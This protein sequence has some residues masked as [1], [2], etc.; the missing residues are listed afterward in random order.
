MK[1][2]LSL[3]YWRNMAENLS[4]PT[5]V[6]IGGRFVDAMSGKTFTV[7]NPAS[8]ET[9][10]Q[11]PLC[12]ETDVANSVIAARKA[13]NTGPWANMPPAE[14]KK[15]LLAFAELILRHKEELALLETLDV[16]KPINDT[17]KEDVP[18]AANAITWFAEAADKIYG[19]VAPGDRSSLAT[20]TREPIGVVAAI[21]P[22]NSPLLIACWILGPA[23]AC[24]SVVILKPA[25]EASLS[26]LRLAELAGQAGLPDGV[27]NVITGAGYTVGKALALHNDVDCLT[28][29]GSTAVGKSLM[30]YSG[31]SNL[32]KIWLECGGKSPII[33]LSDCA[34]FD[35]AAEAVAEAIF[36]NQ[37]AVCTAGSR[38]IIEHSI[39]DMFLEKVIKHAQNFMPNT[40]LDPDST[41]GSMISAAHMQKVLD[42][43]EIGISEGAKLVCGG[44]QFHKETG[45][46]FIEPT[47]FDNVCSSMRIAQEEI[48][49]PV[50]SVISVKNHDEALCVANDSIYGLA[51][52]VWTQDLTVAHWFSQHLRAGNVWVNCYFGDD[53]TLPFG[54]YKQSGNGRDKSLHAFDKF[55]E[56]KST[57]IKF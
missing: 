30:Q 26:C 41:V 29:T 16:G 19:E 20:I 1:K 7:Q 48:F 12:D 53:I 42:Y 5:K 21:I 47:I 39:K 55:T 37:G 51:A 57:V 14:R 25:E 8:G 45:G 34:D 46:Y 52:S 23:L 22:W 54:G 50:L 32:K 56:T 13:F 44:K 18:E 11:L 24:G 10:C 6:L 40:P 38:L 3:A 9:L 31:Q 49:G 36:V 33:V 2:E 35:T 17:F 43:I 28:F 15:I 27:L 4:C